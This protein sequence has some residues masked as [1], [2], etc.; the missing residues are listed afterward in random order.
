MQTINISC[1]IWKKKYPEVATSYLLLFHENVLVFCLI[2][3]VTFNQ[4][5]QNYRI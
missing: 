2:Q 3:T 1:H 4:V 5:S